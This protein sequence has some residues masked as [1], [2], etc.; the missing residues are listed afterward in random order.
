MYQAFAALFYV[1]Q[2]GGFDALMKESVD[3]IVPMRFH[4]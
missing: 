4:W 3:G 2:V 1:F